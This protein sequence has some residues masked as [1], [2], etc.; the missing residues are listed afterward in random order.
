MRRATSELRTVA[1]AVH[2]AYGERRLPS[3]ETVIADWLLPA[4]RALGAAWERGDVS[5]AGEH[6]ASH[7]ILRRLSAAF[8][9]APRSASGRRL[10]VG[11]PAGSRHELGALAFA[12]LAP[13]GRRRRSISRPRPARTR[14]G[15]RGRPAHR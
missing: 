3:T 7:A 8:E 9:A 10:V 12:V 5:I 11:L 15:R 2:A 1:K 6:L 13:A 4:L 14:L